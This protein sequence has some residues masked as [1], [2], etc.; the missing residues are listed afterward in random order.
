MKFCAYCVG[1]TGLGIFLIGCAIFQKIVRPHL[2]LPRAIVC[3]KDRADTPYELPQSRV[4]TYRPVAE[5]Y[6]VSSPFGIRLHP[7]FKRY[8]MHRG[9][10]F[11]SPKGT[12]VRAAADGTVQW[13]TSNTRE[14]TYGRYILLCHDDQYSSLYAHLSKVW[15]QPGQEVLKGDTIGLSGNT[16]LSQGPHLHFEIFHYDKRIDPLIVWEQARDTL[17]SSI[18][19]NRYASNP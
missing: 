3:V 8:R 17:E 16:G 10:D 6:P 12:P 15:V 13:S 14:S 5:G 2:A 4:P 1:L 18:P 11:P 7:I 19:E 9:I